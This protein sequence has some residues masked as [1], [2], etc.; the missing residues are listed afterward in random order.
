MQTALE[1]GTRILARTEGAQSLEVVIERELAAGG[2]GVVLTARDSGGNALIV[3]APRERGGADLS[4]KIE[5]EI[6]RTLQSPNLPKL[7]G[8][9]EELDGTL[10]LVFERIAPN[11]LL[12]LNKSSIRSGISVPSD[13]EARYLPLPGPTALEL[14]RELLL[15]LSEVH[16]AGYV[17]C[18]VKLG[19]L[20]VRCAGGATELNQPFFDALRLGHYRGVLIDAGGMRNVDYLDALNAGH[21]NSSIVPPQCT[22]VYAPPEVVDAPHHY[23][24]S[25]DVYAS[26]MTIYTLVTG[27]VP[28][29]HLERS[30]NPADLSSILDFKRAEA[31]GEISPF[32]REVLGQVRHDDCIFPKGS[33]RGDSFAN[34]LFSILTAA[35]SPKVED[36]PDVSALLASFDLRFGFQPST[37]DATELARRQSV[38]DSSSALTRLSE[39]AGAAAK[40]ESERTRKFPMPELLIPNQSTGTE[41]HEPDTAT[42]LPPNLPKLRTARLP[43]TGLDRIKAAAKTSGPQ[44]RR[45]VGLPHRKSSFPSDPLPPA[46]LDPTGSASRLRRDPTGSASR[47]RRDPTGSASRLQRSESRERPSGPLS[48]GRRRGSA[49]K[50]SPAEDRSSAKERASLL[51]PRSPTASASRLRREDPP[52]S[53]SDTGQRRL[54]RPSSR[55]SVPVKQEPTAS[56]SRLRRKVSPE[57]MSDT[58]QRRL[59]R[60]SSRG[61]VPVLREPRDDGHSTSRLIPSLDEPDSD[62]GTSTRNRALPEA[63]TGYDSGRIKRRLGPRVTG[64]GRQPLSD[65]RSTL[66]DGRAAFLK[67]HR[68]PVLFHELSIAK[69]VPP[70]DATQRI[71]VRGEET[72]R[73]SAVYPLKR[74]ARAL[75]IGRAEDRDLRL[76]APGVSRLHAAVAPDLKSRRWAIVDLGSLNGT[77]VDELPLGPLDRRVLKEGSRIIIGSESLRYFSPKAFFDFL[78]EREKQL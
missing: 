28:Y 48:S 49:N 24:Q 54:K 33:E 23:T 43:S 13:P 39:A 15:A 19:N 63:E 59:K 56:A 9:K 30:L 44:A 11:P 7:R 64:V 68:Y 3:K 55:D 20:L 69:R 35:V 6:F 4:M 60:P 66:L 32:S 36:R 10:F 70:E 12:A 16:K 8:W 37:G 71:R 41:T 18:D 51:R 72:P 31:R 76:E 47:L 5:L 65:Y 21:E 26:A 27:H 2:T 42:P 73:P 78:E 58:G 50:V 14:G 57:S 45:T 22:P 75:S 46:P 67:K 17:H 40:L 53:M 77:T 29:D 34:D 74:A 38:F 1:N 25:M 61:S 52:E 62:D